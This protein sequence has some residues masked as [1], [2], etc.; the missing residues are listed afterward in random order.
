MPKV[1]TIKPL[2]YASYRIETGTVGE[3]TTVAYPLQYNG[4]P[5]YDYY[6]KFP[7][8]TFPIGVHDREIEVLED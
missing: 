3:I 8:I 5:I 6:V 7:D 1:K 2:R 4:H